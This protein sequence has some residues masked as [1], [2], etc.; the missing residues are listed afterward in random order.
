MKIVIIKKFKSKYSPIQLANLTDLPTPTKSKSICT[1]LV[2]YPYKLKIPR[3]F[4]A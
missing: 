1:D 2:R 3:N 4:P